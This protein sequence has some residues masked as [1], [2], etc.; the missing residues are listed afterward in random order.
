[1]WNPPYG[2][3]AFGLVQNEMQ[4]LKF[5]SAVICLIWHLLLGFKYVNNDAPF[6]WNILGLKHAWNGMLHLLFPAGIMAECGVVRLI[7]VIW[8]VKQSCAGNQLQLKGQVC[9]SSLCCL[10]WGCIIQL[11]LGARITLNRHV[12]WERKKKTERGYKEGE[13][14][15]RD[16]HPSNSSLS[17]AICLERKEAR[18][19]DT[20]KVISQHS[21][22]HTHPPA[23]GGRPAVIT[24]WSPKSNM[25]A[26]SIGQ[27]SAACREGPD[28]LSKVS[29][30]STKRWE[31]DNR[32]R[33][34]HQNKANERAGR[35]TCC[36]TGR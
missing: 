29:S 1:M 11:I 27:R 26:A 20:L 10:Q 23:H 34:L 25:V 16:C 8:L 35:G 24:P 17:N 28:S 18:T 13:R 9:S 33:R 19:A 5:Y 31:W 12:G 6:F 3:A 2:V 30:C 15:R 21:R 14:E 32:L 7:R 4:L 22:T 36:P